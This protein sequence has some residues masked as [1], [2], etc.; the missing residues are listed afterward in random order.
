MV[1][2]PSQTQQPQLTPTARGHCIGSN[3]QGHGPLD[4]TPIV[5]VP[6]EAQGQSG[7]VENEKLSIYRH[8]LFPLLAMLFEKCEVATNSVDIV[9]SQAFDQDIKATIVQQA[10][11]GKP[12]FTEDA[13][14]DGLVS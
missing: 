10:K 8:P 9:N 13:E 14:V 1:V 12:F 7:T 5:Q 2:S 4:Q 6:A 3:L 11:E